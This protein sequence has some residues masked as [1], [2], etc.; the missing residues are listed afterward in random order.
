MPFMRL[1]VVERT[2]PA[3]V[4]AVLSV[5]VYYKIGVSEN[6]LFPILIFSLPIAFLLLIAS[7]W[8]LFRKTFDRRLLL[9]ILLF[10]TGFSAALAAQSGGALLEGSAFIGIPASTVQSVDVLLTSDPH[11]L[12]GGRWVAR[13]RLKGSHRP[14]VSCL[15][16]GRITIFGKGE[17]N[18][19]GIGINAEFDGSLVSGVNEGTGGRVS[20]YIFFCDEYNCREW[21]NRI[22]EKRHNRVGALE[23]KLYSGSYNSGVLLSALLLGRRS[24]TESLLIRNFRQSGCMHI[25][26]LSGL[27]VGLLAFALRALLKPVTG[28]IAAS[29]ISA[30]AAVVFLFFV[31]LRPSLFRAVVMYL[32]YTRDSIRAYRVSPLKYL[33]AVFLVQSL[34]FP[35]SVYSLSFKLSYAALCGLLI[36]GRGYTHLL[37]RYLPQKVSAALGAGL[38][39]QFFTLPLIIVSFGIWYPVG[40]IAAPVLTFF[41]SL[42]MVLGSLRLFLPFDSAIGVMV[43]GIADQLVNLISATAGY[44][45]RLPGI[46]LTESLSWLIAA[47]GTILP[48]ILIWSIHRGHHSCYK[49]RF[50]ILDKSISGQPGTGPTKEVGT[51]FSY[52][53]GSP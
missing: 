17:Y 48:I 34:L 46:E 36:S 43:S 24:D 19:L 26:A 8:Q 14:E 50:P 44:S 20:E 2:T 15:S 32:L 29:L 11:Q 13:G 21:K 4:G 51:E 33:S 3:A 37:H 35:L 49:S 39:A 45:A 38:G 12:S 22:Y 9:S 25:L 52:Q 30:G 18:R 1:T 40:I 47:T 53:P 42:L 16:R 6:L 23:H 27:H 5:F 7:A 28:F 10:G 31:G 41:S